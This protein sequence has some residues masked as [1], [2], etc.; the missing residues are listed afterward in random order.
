M[1]GLLAKIVRNDAMKSDPPEIYNWRVYVLSCSVSFFSS[2][3]SS[4]RVLTL[5]GMFCWWTVWYGHW[6]HRRCFEDGHIPKVILYLLGTAEERLTKNVCRKFGLENLDSVG[7]ANLEANIVSTL[8]AGC[9]FGA[10]A[11]Y[12]FADRFG[13]RTS[14]FGCACIAI[15]GT[16]M[17]AVSLGHLPVMYIGRL[18]TGFAVG[19][20][21]MLNPLY[22]SE[23]APRAI[24][25]ALTGMYQ[26]FVCTPPP[27]LDFRCLGN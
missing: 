12:W 4:G 5:P 24:R 21:S 22:T 20:A 17:Q 23:N 11:A 10:L 7:S 8:Q 1:G 15:V 19:G 27:N 13:R 16:V 25:G 14:L 9:F 26:F 3:L 18:I 6:Y 2:R